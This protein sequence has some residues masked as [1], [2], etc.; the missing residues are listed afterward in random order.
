MAQFLGEYEC[1][2]DAKGRI[3]LP[4]SLKKQLNPTANGRFV[5]NRGFEKCLILWPF[6]QW[7]KVIGRVN[8]LNTFRRKERAFVRYFYRGATEIVMDAT[9]RL[10]LPK[11]LFS[12]ARID[13]SVLLCAQNDVIEIWNKQLYEDLLSIDSDA[14]ADLAEEVM[15][16]SNEPDDEG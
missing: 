11:P 12:Y 4:I 16:G 2:L 7:E 15:G 13:K 8:K 6:D 3:K 9:D 10:N 5:I 14:F 1:N